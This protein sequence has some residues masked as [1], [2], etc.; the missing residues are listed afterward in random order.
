MRRLGEKM[1]NL[2]RKTKCASIVSTILLGGTLSFVVQAEEESKGI[3]TITVTASKRIQT[4]QE[5]PMSVSALGEDELSSRGIDELGEYF[6]AIP[7]VQYT[8]FGATGRRGERNVSMRGISG[9]SNGG[10]LVG[11]YIDE[12]PMPVSDPTLFDVERIEVLRGPQGTLYGAGTAGGTIKVITNKPDSEYHEGKIDLNTSSTVDGGENYAVKGMINIPLVENKLALR[13]VGYYDNADGFID[14]VAAVPVDPNVIVNNRSTPDSIA[15]SEKVL[16]ENL[17]S[18]EVSGFR[19]NLQYTPTDDLTISALANIHRAEMGGEANYFPDVGELQISRET[20]TPQESNFDLFNLTLTY[21]FSDMSFV[22]AT[23]YFE[24]EYK[25]IEDVSHDG[26]RIV[27]DFFAGAV[28][29][30]GFGDAERDIVSAFYSLPDAT[31]FTLSSDKKETTQEFRLMSIDD[32]P[33]QWTVGLYYH[34]TELIDLGN[35]STTHATIAPLGIID[36]DL[37]FADTTNTR[38]TE[39]YAVFGEAYYNITDKLRVTL[40]GRYFDFSLD[41]DSLGFGVALGGLVDPDPIS[42]SETGFRPKVGVSY[43]AT[44]DDLFF[45]SVTEGFR[46]GGASSPVGDTPACE[47]ALAAAGLTESPTEF[48]ADSIWNYELGTKTSWSDGSVIANVT[49][50]YVD[51]SNIAQVLPLGAND[52]GCSFSPTVNGG[53]ATSQ[54]FELETQFQPEFLEGSDFGLAVAYTDTELGNGSQAGAEGESLLNVPEWTMSLYGEYEFELTDSLY[55]FVRADV[56]YIGERA[57]SYDSIADGGKAKYLDS[58]NLSNLRLGVRADDW[59]LALYVNNITDERP[60]LGVRD[61][62]SQFDRFTTL[63]PRTAGLSFSRD[64]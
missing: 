64:F 36:G 37:L 59:T 62:G 35:S 46:S 1:N 54:G 16:E 17:N 43:Q 58:Y 24:G 33:F 5:V 10:P 52:S 51:W 57:W 61:F 19:A 8:D 55:G 6:R 15:N 45:A 12:T 44:E 49:A 29:G 23:S 50:F 18:S 34:K 13:V 9:G 63:R 56:Q 38:E 25:G 39:E 3:E 2:F 41:E 53:S 26:R 20:K 30:P 40:G 31:V 32:S 48:E 21:D 11:Y 42:S 47:A 7:G 22:S 27:Q 60:D 14:S 4:I 28:F